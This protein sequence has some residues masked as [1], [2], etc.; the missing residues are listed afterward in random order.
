MKLEIL[1][2]PDDVLAAPCEPVQQLDDEIRQLANDMAETMYA[3]NGIGLAAPQVGRN[4]RL[5]VVDITGPEEQN[6]LITL[7]NPE[8][9]SCSDETMEYEEGCLS[10]PQLTALTER[11]AKVCVRGQD[12]TGAAQTIE[13]EGLLAICL[14]HEMDH[15]DGVLI[16]DKVSRLKRSLYEKKA[17]KW[18]KRPES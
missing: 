13:A 14:Q 16:V 8:L 15:L 9:V 11:P 10:C 5:I 7:I 18:K 6:G 17:R 1:T 3:S 2:Y 12:A 4:I